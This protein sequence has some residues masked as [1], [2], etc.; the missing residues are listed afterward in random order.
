VE[1]FL[2]GGEVFAE[3]SGKVCAIW[4]F[5]CVAICLV[6]VCTQ[7]FMTHSKVSAKSC[8]AFWVEAYSTK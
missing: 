4:A 1:E 3:I 6:K 2:E 5:T 8:H 7:C